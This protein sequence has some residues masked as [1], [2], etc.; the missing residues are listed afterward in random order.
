[1]LAGVGCKDYD[2]DID[3][4]ND[5]LDELTT[6]KIA[7]LESQLGSLQTAV[8]NLKSADDALGKRID[9]LKSDADANAKDI[10]ALEKAQDQLQ[11]DID[12]IEKDLADNYV[13]KSY[14]NTTLSSYATTKY[15]GDAVAAV[16]NNLGKFTTE[17][18]IHD[19]INASKDAAIAAAGDD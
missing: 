6:G 11:K 19:A 14:L 1:M 8:D 3:K 16:T 10:E 17:K 12:A 5:R 4:L 18:A 7:T 9:E 2:D 13:T 15:V